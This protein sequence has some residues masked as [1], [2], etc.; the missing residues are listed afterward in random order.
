[1]TKNEDEEKDIEIPGEDD[2]NVGG[3]APKKKKEKRRKSKEEK[4]AERKVIFWTMVIIFVITLGFWLV[5]KV[6][7]I[8]KGESLKVP[9]KE[10]TVEKTTTPKTEPKNYVEITL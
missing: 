8:L 3:E 1:M 7:G 6:G 5:P 9:T 4:I 2:E 10:N